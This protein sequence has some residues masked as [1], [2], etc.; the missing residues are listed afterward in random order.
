MRDSVR[1]DSQMSD[2][3]DIFPSEDGSI[4][5]VENHLSGLKSYFLQLNSFCSSD[6]S[7]GIENFNQI[8]C[9]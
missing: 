9:Q 4:T 2:R 6:P 1:N 5:S 3:S 7:D 8:R